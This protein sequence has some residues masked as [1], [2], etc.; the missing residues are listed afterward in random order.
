MQATRIVEDNYNPIYNARLCFP[1]FVPIL[2]DKITIRAWSKNKRSADTFIAN[3]PEYPS[4][5]DCFNITKLLSCEGKIRATWFNLYG[6][7]P[8]DRS[9]F[10]SATTKKK[11][12]SYYLGRVLL[13]LQIAPND[14]PQL[15][16]TMANPQKEPSSAN[17]LLWVDVYDLVNCDET[18][19][20]P[21]WI[22]TTIGNYQ[23]GKYQ[24]K[25]KDTTK[26]Y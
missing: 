14:K 24:A 26:S 18:G 20:K 10:Q 3:I 16:A 5:H 9:W 1:V 21:V 22:Q 4:P 2:N 19:G 17:F 11:E 25:Y 15:F 12:G 6:I 23:S 13:S 8:L 7:H